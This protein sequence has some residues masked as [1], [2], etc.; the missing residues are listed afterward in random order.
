[1]L[2]QILTGY[3]FSLVNLKTENRMF[4]TNFTQVKNAS[5][6]YNQP[7][8]YHTSIKISPISLEQN[9]LGTQKQIHYRC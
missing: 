8:I 2:K 7:I 6:Q 5:N 9:C 1:M 4:K 3:N